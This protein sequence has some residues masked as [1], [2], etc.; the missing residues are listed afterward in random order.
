MTRRTALSPARGSRDGAT[1]TSSPRGGK[2]PVFG[3]RLYL[4]P[5]KEVRAAGNQ[6]AL[7]AFEGYIPV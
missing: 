5:C 7:G 3:A 2:V 4:P 6:F 1:T